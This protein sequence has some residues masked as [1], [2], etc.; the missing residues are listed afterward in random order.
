MEQL[1][2]FQPVFL[3]ILGIMFV[4]G[5]VVAVQQYIKKQ[6]QPT[7]TKI[8]RFEND[9]LELKTENRIEQARTREHW[10]DVKITLDT[11]RITLHE[12]ALGQT[13]LKVALF[14]SDNN[15]GIRGE[16]RALREDVNGL[17]NTLTDVRISQAAKD[18]E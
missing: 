9:L 7:E 13:E 18:R 15:N 5:A 16:V 11:V 14:G 2:P 12:L 4:V 3:T 10:N 1:V 8:D 6:T 17:R